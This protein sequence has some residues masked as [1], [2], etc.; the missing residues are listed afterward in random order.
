MNLVLYSTGCPKCEILKKKLD[1]AKVSYTEVNN[2]VEMVKLGIMSV[3]VLFVDGNK[4]DYLES[5]NWVNERMAE[6]NE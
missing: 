2:T 5:I 4:L 1:V 3:P 6:V